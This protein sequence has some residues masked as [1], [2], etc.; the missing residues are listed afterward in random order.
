MNGVKSWLKRSVEGEQL[1]Q[2]ITYFILFSVLVIFLMNRPPDLPGWRFYG[3]VLALAI[4]LVINI[5]WGGRNP[6]RPASQAEVWSFLILWSGLI[7]T[8]LWL[9]EL[10]NAVY[11]FLALCAQASVMRGVWPAG[12]IFTAINL[13]IVLGIF[14]VMGVTGANLASLASSLLMGVIFILLLAILLEHYAHQTRRAERLLLELQAANAELEA[15]RQKEK[16]LAI[17]E[18]RV[19]LARDIH[20]G[21]GHHLTVLSIQLQAAAKLVERN[22]Q[23]AAESIQVCRSEAQAALEEVRR[24]VAVMRQSPGEAQPLPAAL[25]ALV[26]NFNRGASIHAIFEKSGSFVELSPFAYQ[27][28]FRAAQEGL[29]NAQKHGKQV[30]QAWVRLDYS[31]NGVRL[32][33]QDDGQEA[34]PVNGECCPDGTGFGLA[35][36]SERVSQLGG[37]LRSGPL[38]AGGFE[39][40]IHLPIQEATHDPGSAG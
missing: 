8:A 22:P 11:I 10:S 29:T 21:L 3:A 20:D 1:L 5:L 26:K 6:A 30:R 37:S 12:L 25:E 18:E 36:L 16:E 4:L 9:G 38:A 2:W 14:R 33:V 17:A 35:G 39:L 15:A 27:T 32:T 23:A 34:G 24:S 7:S 40:A 31:G 28:L 13:T 19:R